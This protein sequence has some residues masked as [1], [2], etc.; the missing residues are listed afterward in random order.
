[1]DKVEPE[2]WANG[3]YDPPPAPT[4]DV[5][6]NPEDLVSIVRARPT[7]PFGFQGVR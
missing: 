4:L 1:V 5:E 2:W 3:Q 7:V 6:E